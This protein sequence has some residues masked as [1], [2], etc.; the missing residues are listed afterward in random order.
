MEA[1]EAE[2]AR[3]RAALQAQREAERAAQEAARREEAEKQRA[4]NEAHLQQMR[5]ESTARREAHEAF[6]EVQRQKREANQLRHAAAQEQHTRRGATGI[7][8]PPL[9]ETETGTTGACDQRLATSISTTESQR[10]DCLHSH[11]LVVLFAVVPL[12][13][14]AVGPHQRNLA[15]GPHRP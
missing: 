8:L 6:M 15:G 2:R 10:P 12:R 4:E 5:V 11:M 14:Q 13:P 3:E 7:P 9:H 1:Q